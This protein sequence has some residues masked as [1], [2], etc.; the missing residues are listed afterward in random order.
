[1]TNV[2]DGTRTEGPAW[3]VPWT[4]EEGA[5]RATR[6]FSQ[7]FGYEPASVTSAPGRLNVIGEHTDYNAGLA[8]PTVLAHR[9][10]V[11]AAGRGDGVVRVVTA[12]AP[13]EAPQEFELGS[14]APGA[15][16]GWAAYVG[17][18]LWALQE[19]GFVGGGLDLAV[20]SCVPIAKGLGSSA[21]LEAAVALAADS[22]WGLALE[23]PT[24]RAQ[25][26]EACV[27]GERQFVGVPSGPL[28]QFAS[29]LTVPGAALILDFASSPPRHWAQ[30]LY[31][32]EYGLGLLVI[33]SG[34]T[35]THTD[36]RY[37]DRVAECSAAA[38][39][40]GVETLRQVADAPYAL[41]RVDAI[42]DPVLRRRARHVV[43]EIERT[44]L[45]AAELSGTAPAHERFVTIGKAMYRS[46]ASLEIDFEVSTPEQDASVDAAFGAG[47]LG[48]R[49]VGG[50]FGGAAIA[51]V[52]RTQAHRTA[53]VISEAMVDQGYGEPTYLMV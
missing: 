29:L 30:P 16:Y 50:G 31:F 20:E 2:T 4:A 6:L 26:A 9:T 27:D 10:F 3:R 33:D 8:L 45:V 51:L 47:A 28:D 35:R 11:A 23:T 52:R 41:R 40:L 22:L 24:G 39:A 12:H 13:A 17:S 36:G 44:R 43:T 42:E 7:A 1:M 5:E 37:A 49:L 38:D 14:L 53:E 15:I 25:L 21:A 46:H 34:T 19:R 48:A 18:V 32:P